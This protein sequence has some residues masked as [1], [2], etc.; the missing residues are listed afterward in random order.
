MIDLSTNGRGMAIL[1]LDSL[2]RHSFPL[3]NISRPAETKKQSHDGVRSS[4]TLISNL[5]IICRLGIFSIKP[6]STL[7]KKQQNNSWAS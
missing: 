6:A 4:L 3:V 1:I 2:G 5:G 7:R